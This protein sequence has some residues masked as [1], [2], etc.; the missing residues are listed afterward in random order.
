M[1]SVGGTVP[2]RMDSEHQPAP[3]DCDRSGRW[4]NG[5][6]IFDL[7]SHQW[8]TDY[9]AEDQGEYTLASAI[10]NVIGGR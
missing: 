9:D 2:P 8:G 6:A 4:A 1:L 3:V 5:L 10:T 7:R